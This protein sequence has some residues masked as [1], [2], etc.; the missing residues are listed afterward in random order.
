MAMAIAAIAGAAG[1]RAIV[2]TARSVMRLAALYASESRLIGPMLVP[3]IETGETD[4]AHVRPSEVAAVRG[5][6]SSSGFP[7]STV[8]DLRMDTPT[9]PGSWCARSCRALRRVSAMTPGRLL[10][11][12]ETSREL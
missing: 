6:T 2:E 3:P 10:G 8:P 7:V 5:P 4:S 1:I 11:T 9:R 12:G